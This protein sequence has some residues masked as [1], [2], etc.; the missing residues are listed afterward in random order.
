MTYPKLTKPTEMKK[1]G[2]KKKSSSKP[3]P[4][5][6]SLWSRAKSMARSKFDV[7][8]SAYANAW[9]SKWYKSKG[10]GWRGGKKKAA[11]G[12]EPKPLT[13]AEYNKIYGMLQKY[14]PMSQRA[15]ASKQV[16]EK[17]LQGIMTNLFTD[18][19]SLKYT[20]NL[21]KNDTL[22]ETIASL[23][24]ADILK[25][26][27]GGA[28]IGFGDI[29]GATRA[30][31][32]GE[33]PSSVI[34]Q[35]TFKNMG[36]DPAQAPDFLKEQVRQMGQVDKY[37]REKT[38][39]QKAEFDAELDSKM[40]QLNLLN[41]GEMFDYSLAM[42]GAVPYRQM[43]EGGN[44][45]PTPFEKAFAAARAAGKKTFMFEGKEFTTKTA[46]EESGAGFAKYIQPGGPGTID[47][48]LN[49]PENVAE[50]ERQREAQE[51]M[52]WYARSSG[53]LTPME[54]LDDPIFN[55]LLGGR[56]LLP[57]ART[58]AATALG[59]Q[60]NPLHPGYNLYPRTPGSIG[61]V[62]PMNIYEQAATNIGRYGTR[63]VATKPTFINRAADFVSENLPRF[64]RSPSADTG[65]ATFQRGFQTSGPGWVNPALPVGATQV[66]TP[67]SEADGG[68]ISYQQG[69]ASEGDLMKIQNGGTHEESPLGG[70]P[71]GPD[72]DGRQVLVEEGE[73]IRKG[74]EQDFV[75]SDRLKL[76]KQE[77][78]EFGIDKKFVGKSFAAI[79]E[80]LEKRSPRKSD[81]IDRQTLDIQLNK[82]EEAQETFKERK[83]AEAKEMYGDPEAEMQQGPMGPPPGAMPGVGTESAPS[84]EQFAGS[85]PQAQAML[86]QR[87]PEQF[88]GGA[89]QGMPPP[90]MA[91]GMPPGMPA[92]MPQ[93]AAPM[94]MPHG[95]P[96]KEQVNP[97]MA[98]SQQVFDASDSATKERLAAMYP[99]IYRISA[100]TP[101]LEELRIAQGLDPTSGL[102]TL[103]TLR[104]AQGLD[105]TSGLPTFETLGPARMKAIQSNQPI[106]QEQF[107]KLDPRLKSEYAEAFPGLYKISADTPTLDDLRKLGVTPKVSKKPYTVD[108]L[109]G[110][111]VLPMGSEITPE[112]QNFIDYVNTGEG[113]DKLG[114]GL[115]KAEAVRKNYLSTQK[116]HGGRFGNYHF[117]DGRGA[118][119]AEDVQ[120]IMS[121]VVDNIGPGGIQPGRYTDP[122]VIAAQNAMV[123][124]ELYQTG[125]AGNVIPYSPG[126]ALNYAA[127]GPMGQV[128]Q[129]D[130]VGSTFA[131][132]PAVDAAE[133]MAAAESTTLGQ[134]QGSLLESDVTVIPAG[135]DETSTDPESS[136]GTT[137]D[138]ANLNRMRT[139]TADL[140]KVETVERDGK[141]V[142][143][144]TYKDGSTQEF[145][146]PDVNTPGGLNLLQGAPIATN[147]MTAEMLPDKFNFANY[148][149]APDDSIIQK[150]DVTPLIRD[151]EKMVAT[152]RGIVGSRASSTAELL[153]GLANLTA[154]GMAETG[155]IRNQQYQD[156]LEEIRNQ[157]LINLN[158]AKTNSEMRAAV[159]TANADLEKERLSL[160][161]SAAT[162][163]SKLADSL[164]QE[165][166]SKY[167]LEQMYI[168][169]P[170][171]A[172]QGSTEITTTE[173]NGN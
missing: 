105:P 52:D 81:P 166:L 57:R 132:A 84:P 15:G 152:G 149:L 39:E 148:R 123:S 76:T 103:E 53:A 65:T 150:R 130:I 87:F 73:T 66:A 159:D 14:F 134:G 23:G 165:G 144:R 119:S 62:Q 156:Y 170:Y 31:V 95:G 20:R 163:A 74:D 164:R 141:K 162:E 21:L 114:Q 139:T 113:G 118:N 169:Y 71:L 104:G 30:H 19:D 75:F 69:G 26:Y 32:F 9:A 88:G 127:I 173:G 172:A 151:V 46:E 83:L 56:M 34:M 153:T 2:K 117:A 167:E 37:G 43:D 24:S 27:F 107:D 125:E 155:K 115:G 17:Q 99:N 35:N 108:D 48:I 96:H 44:P 168:M 171:L 6:P 28:D 98:P 59:P 137:V 25:S 126:N 47:D 38:A 97:G 80:K 49:S 77:A 1:G 147:L 72:A 154:L 124:P 101:T 58:A 112:I 10:G 36:I 67:R 145:V 102:P 11:G 70:V 111:E 86:A 12:S 146:I 140:Q 161:N 82:L 131:A 93:G 61:G 50:R 116:A 89:P 60:H 29:V 55:I 138:A 92:G 157:Q 143:V 64:L 135:Q 54:G 63:D 142:I 158:I 129:S 4:T 109:M 90:G 42:G 94:M 106:S 120:Q 100:D 122:N 121:G 68:Y 3:K 18:A 22:D 128:M 45:D 51:Q 136:E 91:P 79:S 110:S 33:N 78:E 160:I 41:Q 16:Y 40:K 85:S 13:D 5:N 8:P 133:S 7:Y